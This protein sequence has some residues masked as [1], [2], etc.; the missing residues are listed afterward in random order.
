VKGVRN[1]KRGHLTYLYPGMI[2]DG[3]RAMFPIHP[4]HKSLHPFP[5]K[6]WDWIGKSQVMQST[7]SQTTSWGRQCYG[8]KL[9]LWMDGVNPTGKLSISLIFLKTW[10]FGDFMK[11][12]KGFKWISIIDTNG[13]FWCLNVFSKAS[14]C[15]LQTILEGNISHYK[16]AP[17]SLSFKNWKVKNIVFLI[18]DGLFQFIKK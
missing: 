9:P 13:M 18:Y 11:S 6:T 12:Q 10:L 4:C 1:F 14:D 3:K 2:G 7:N 15:T 16:N 5:L 8:T 17:V